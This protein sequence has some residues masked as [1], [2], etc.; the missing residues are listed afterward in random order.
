MRTRVGRLEAP[1]GVDRHREEGQ[2]GGDHRDG[3]PAGQP[4]SAEPDDDHRRDR[5]DRD[6]L[7]RDDVGQEPALEEGGVHERDG[8]EKADSC[9]ER[10][11][12]GCLLRGEE[13][14]LP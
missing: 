10:E 3:E 11:A 6:R 14:C 1:E 7:R 12:H 9:A 8:D 13:R 4:A 5:E 2:V